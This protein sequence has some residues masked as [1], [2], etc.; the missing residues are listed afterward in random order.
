MKRSEN[1]TSGGF[2]ALGDISMSIEC[3]DVPG[4]TSSDHDLNQAGVPPEEL[5]NSTIGSTKTN[6]GSHSQNKTSTVD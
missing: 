1:G 2:A 3:P 4:L 5:Q 6:S